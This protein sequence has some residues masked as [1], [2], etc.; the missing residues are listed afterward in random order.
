MN[1]EMK[2]LFTLF[3][4]CLAFAINGQSL[5]LFHVDSLVIINPNSMS[6]GEGHIELVNTDTVAHDYYCKVARIG[7]TG[8]VDSSYFCWDLCY[9]VG[10]SISMGTVSIA[11]GATAYDFSG[12][13]HPRNNN[14]GMDTIWYTFFNALDANDSLQVPLVFSFDVT[15]SQ[16]ESLK[17]SVS[18]YPNPARDVLF[19]N[20]PAMNQ[21]S[22]LVLID[23][24]GRRVRSQKLLPRSVSSRMSLHGLNQGMYLLVRQSEG[25]QVT[26]G[27]VAIQP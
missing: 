13:A 26:F 3:S 2:Q 20:Y 17:A 16:N 15:A 4:F 11:A 27:K 9:G 6:V 23:M 7:S 22:Q 25:K 18:M 1:F 8:L 21:S 10:G 24:T 19:V 14:I 5:T 12:Y